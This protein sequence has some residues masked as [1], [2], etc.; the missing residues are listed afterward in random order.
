MY[1]CPSPQ[2]DPNAGLSD[3]TRVILNHIFKKADFFFF[4]LH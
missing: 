1:D 3:L 2:V 4:V